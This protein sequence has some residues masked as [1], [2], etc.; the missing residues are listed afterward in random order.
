VMGWSSF[1]SFF[2]NLPGGIIV[3]TVG[4]T[5]S[6]LSLSIALVGPPY[7]FLGF[8]T[9][10]VVA[11]IVVTFVRTGS[12][13]WHPAPLSFLIWRRVL[14][15]NLLP[16]VLMGFVVWRLLAKAGTVRVEA[17][18]KELTSPSF[19]PQE[20]SPHPSRESLRIRE[21]GARY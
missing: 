19:R 2:V 5:G 11:M 13:L 21:G 14:I 1:T 6:L 4:K 17:N 15:L 9:S 8:N 16:G 7:F 20:F 18:G 10:Y 12:N 3:D